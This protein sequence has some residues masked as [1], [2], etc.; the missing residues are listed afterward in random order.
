MKHSK[1]FAPP[2]FP[3]SVCH[4]NVRFSPLFLEKK[5]GVEGEG[6]FL[7]PLPVVVPA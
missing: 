5:G 7:P 3:S 6:R 1:I 2:P 4:A